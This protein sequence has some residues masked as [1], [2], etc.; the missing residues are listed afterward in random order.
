[1][2]S[3]V[4]SRIEEFKE[5]SISA[6]DNKLTYLQQHSIGC[7]NWPEIHSYSPLTS[8]SIAHDS[9]HIYVRFNV[10]GEDLRAVNH[11]NL[12]LVAQDSCVEFFLQVPGSPEY[13]NFEFNC[14][15]T[16]NA[17][18]RVARPDAVRLNDEQIAS[19]KRFP[20]CGFNPFDEKHGIHTWSLTIA[21]PMDLIG[22]SPDAFP[23]HIMA[24]FYK[25]ADKT[26]HP[27]YVSWSPIKTEKPN[28]HC[29]QFFGKLILE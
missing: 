18:H 16:V 10:C 25:C 24:N 7:V 23:G 9:Q 17:S 29:P 12:S 2:K 21:I 28:F 14:I 8:F 20:S 6:I 27:H 22:V 26:S 11:A 5:L 19:I 1:M 15:G 3:L 13:W 4:V